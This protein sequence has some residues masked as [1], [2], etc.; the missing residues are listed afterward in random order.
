MLMA[1]REKRTSSTPPLRRLR[2]ICTLVLFWLGC[3]A[4]IGAQPLT[5]HQQLTRAIFKELVEIDTTS[6]GGDTGRAAD[7]MAARLRAAGFAARDV[8]VFKPAPGK[9]N[10]VARLRG[11]GAQK[12]ILLLAHLDVVPAHRADWSFD[13]FK[14]TERD[15]NFYGR[16][17]EDDKYMAA[18]FVANLVRYRNEGFMPN[19]DII[20]ALTAD[21]EIGGRWGIDWLLQT[22]R[23]LVDA[24]LALNEG[25]AVTLRQGKAFRVSVATAEKITAN[26]RLEVTNKGGHSAVPRADNAIYQLAEGLV[27]LSKFSFPINLNDTTREFFGRVEKIETPPMAAAIRSVLAGRDDPAAVAR[28]L[29]NLNYSAQLHSN[30]VATMLEGGHAPNALP[31]TARA[32]VNCRI[33]PN[34]K[35]EDVRAALI[36]ALADERISVSQPAQPPAAAPSVID[37]SLMKAIE[38]TAAEF[39]PDARVLPVLSVGSTDSRLLRRA[40]IPTFGHSGL[41]SDGNGNSHGKDEHVNVKSFF[42][43]GEYLYRL[44]KRLSGGG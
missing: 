10:L 3:P 35:V 7:A 42:E 37:P 2:Q 13:P 1:Y 12:P 14:L 25:A 34:E 21:E 29:G 36:G 5:A 44:V 40:G 39:W 18:A 9:G 41:P 43:G 24:E 19:R 22:H 38:T 33:L 16:G 17:T 11:S 26:F 23:D 15:G 8:Q 28:V 31:Q 30:C 27:R 6:N 20:V 32:T 4:A